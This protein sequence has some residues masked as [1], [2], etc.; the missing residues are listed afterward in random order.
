[1]EDLTPKNKEERLS[2]QRRL[3]SDP[4][5]ECSALALAKYVLSFGFFL[6]WDI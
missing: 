5:W 1:M 6:F 2:S 4:N 3:E